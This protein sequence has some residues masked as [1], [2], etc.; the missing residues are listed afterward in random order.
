MANHV[1]IKSAHEISLAL[2]ALSDKVKANVWQGRAVVRVY[3]R[4]KGFNA[5]YITIRPDGEPV[6]RDIDFSIGAWSAGLCDTTSNRLADCVHAFYKLWLDRRAVAERAANAAH[7]ARLEADSLPKNSCC[8]SA[9]G[10][11]F[12]VCDERGN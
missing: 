8:A 1:Q 3:V 6:T 4:T 5:G 9:F 2:N 7:W 10:L 12:L 11:P